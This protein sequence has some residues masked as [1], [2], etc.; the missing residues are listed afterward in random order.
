MKGLRAQGGD[1]VWLAAGGVLGRLEDRAARRLQTRN[2]LWI[3]RKRRSSLTKEAFTP[4]GEN[5]LVAVAVVVVDF[6]GQR[7]HW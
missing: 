6:H 3:A 5:V 7:W 1:Y 4:G 2:R